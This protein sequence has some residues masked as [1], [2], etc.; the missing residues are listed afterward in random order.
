[1]LAN[2]RE[3]LNVTI[4]S[5]VLTIG[6]HPETGDVCEAFICDRGKPGSELDHT[7]ARIGTVISKAI[8]G[9]DVED[10]ELDNLLG[11]KNRWTNLL[12]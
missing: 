8:Q 12:E 3:C 2:R 5:F 6:Y 11:E 4:D 10:M 7:L 9:E 1:M